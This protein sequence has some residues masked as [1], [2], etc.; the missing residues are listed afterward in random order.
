MV[1]RRSC[2]GVGVGVGDLAGL[3]IGL[4][5]T[6]FFAATTLDVFGTPCYSEFQSWVVSQHDHVSPSSGYARLIQ[7]LTGEENNPC[8]QVRLRVEMGGQLVLLYL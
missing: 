7:V 2:F 5:L 3:R 4:N 8:I 6:F 1:Q